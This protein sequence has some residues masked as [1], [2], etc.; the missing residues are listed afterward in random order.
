MSAF[1]QPV[2]II[3]SLPLS[4]KPCNAQPLRR[5]Y[6]V[7][8]R[9]RHEKKV[10]AY[11]AQLGWESYLPL[12][13]EIHWWSDRRKV[14]EMPL[15]PGYIFLR[16]P[17]SSHYRAAVARVPGVVS[18]VGWNGVPVPILDREIESIQTLLA[19]RI[20]LR[21]YQFLPA[22]RKVR[23]RG[24]SLEGIEGVLVSSGN[25]RNLIVSVQLI[26]RSVSMR[27]DGYDVVPA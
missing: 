21:P 19:R 15:F 3:E 11:F 9:G 25:E 10:S 16:L 18:L 20:L 24:G 27:L 17:V 1:A 26:Q 12:I 14:V 8:T 13:P 5:W 22:G 2:P 6:A 4:V 7:W 23:I